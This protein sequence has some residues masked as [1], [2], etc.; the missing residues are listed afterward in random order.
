M[1]WIDPSQI[2]AAATAPGK[3]GEITFRR[4]VGPDEVA[5]IFTI[6]ADGSGERQIGGRAAH[7]RSHARPPLP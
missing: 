1:A 5:T 3:N 6:R 4:F 7:D 2:A